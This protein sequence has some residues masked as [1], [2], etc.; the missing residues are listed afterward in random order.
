MERLQA[1]GYRWCT[2]CR[3]VQP[4][5]A[6]HCRDCDCCVLRND[7]HCPFVNNCI[8]QRNYVYFCGFLFSLVC[9]GIAVFSGIA[10]WFTDSS[11]D[12]HPQISPTV[13]TTIMWGLVV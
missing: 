6:K 4:P 11:P 10:L 12:Y 8:G 5:R 7:H 2:Y 1:Q 13:R 9:L 3:M